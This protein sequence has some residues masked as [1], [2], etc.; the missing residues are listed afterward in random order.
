MTI[1]TG[2]QIIPPGENRCVWMTAGVLQY[3]LCDRD[4]RCEECPLDL[5]IRR[6]VRS[7]VFVAESAKALR[8]TPPGPELKKE[9]RYSSNHCWVLEIAP[10]SFRVGIEPGFAA[11]I[12]RP[13]AIVLPP[14]GQ[15]VREGQT[16][17]WI[18]TAGGTLT[19]EAALR[20]SVEAAN[21]SLRESPHLL[22]Q[23]P[24]DD[25]WLYEVASDE[26]AVKEAGLVSAD[27]IADSYAA[28]R[29]RFLAA[30]SGMLRGHRPDRDLSPA[31]LEHQIESIPDQVGHEKYFSALRQIYT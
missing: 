22:H 5:A 2:Y 8:T 28:D 31:D 30:L 6:Q 14:Q 17:A 15:A 21:I 7:P 13:R 10:G 18:V 1:Y 12:G 27:R 20:G 26:N 25:G 29:S 19:L 16:C 11:A 9:L 4:F 24:F 3:Q 23:H